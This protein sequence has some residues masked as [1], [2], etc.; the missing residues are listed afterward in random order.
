MSFKPIRF[1]KRAADFQAFY[2]QIKLTRCPHCQRTG[3]LILHG[4]LSGYDEKSNHLKTIRG[5]RIFCSNRDRR[6]GCGRT[7]SVLATHILKNF[8]ITTKSLWDFLNNIAQGMNKRAAFGLLQLPFSVSS[9]YRLYQRIYIRQQSIR[10][11]L[12]K[13]SP[14][15]IDVPSRNPLIKTILHIKSTFTRSADPLATFQA[16]FQASLL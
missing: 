8:T 3:C 15:P 9:I 12:L 10:T 13:H 14:P 11:L 7:F 2:R 16:R 1:Y 6:Q 4:Y 5:R